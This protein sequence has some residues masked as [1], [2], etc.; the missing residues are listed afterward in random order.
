MEKR[1]NIKNNLPVL[2]LGEIGLVQN[3]GKAGIPVYAG[4]EISDNP[5]L[6]SRYTKRKIFFSDYRSETFI[7]ELCEFGKSLSHKTVLVSDDDH[8]ILNIAKHQSK[9]SQWFL[10][11]FPE[12]EMVEKLLDKQLFCELIEK[13]DL[14]SPKSVTLSDEEDLDKTSGLQLPCIIKPSFKQAWWNNDFEDEVGDYQKAIKCETKEELHQKYKEIAK[15]D[16]HVVV[17]EYIPGNEDQIYSVNLFAD[18]E[19]EVKGHFI[20][21]KFRTYPLSAGEGSYIM[22]VRDDEMLEIT[23]SIIKKLQLKGLLNIQFKRHE[24]T[25]KPVLLEIHTRNSVWS[26]LGTA[27]GVNVAAMYYQ[28][29][30]GQKE[31]E[32]NESKPGVVFIFLEK[33]I[34]AF[35]QNI[36]SR[37]VSYGSWI[38]SYFQKFVPGGYLISDPLPALMKIWFVTRRRLNMKKKVF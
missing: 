10:F 7:D 26:Y 29:L 9:L 5:S 31:I 36:K 15:I 35:A 6:Y 32:I 30:I 24:R 33:D 12:P 17:Q 37:Q 8:A 4:S 28:N 23:K 18:N 20:A 38:K 25:G 34:K 13:Y 16:P 1:V 22:T 3:F 21:R 2:V 11:S 19:S 14:P 27:S